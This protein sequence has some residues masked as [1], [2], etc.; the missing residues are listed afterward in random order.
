MSTKEFFSKGWPTRVAFLLGKYLPP[1]GGDSLARLAARLLVSVDSD[2]RAAVFDNQRHVLGAE[3]TPAAVHQSVYTVFRNA[4]RAYYELFH[5]IGRG[6]TRVAEFKPPVRILPETQA[7]LEAALTSGRGLFLLGI[8]M[9]NFDLAGIALCQEIP[10]PVQ[11][12]G[13]ADP[14][15]GFEIF[16]RLRQQAGA[17]ITPISPETLRQ[18]IRRLQEGGVVITGVDRPIGENDTPVTFFGAQAHLPTGYM[19][20]ALRARCLLMT[21]TCFYEEGEYRIVANPP[22]EPVF[23]GDRERDIDINVQ[24]VLQEVEGLIRR[25]PEQWMMF[26]PVWR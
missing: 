14:A 10:V 21:A 3:A 26:V 16:N 11:V 8:H 6:H 15:P 25:H 12:L 2:I 22:W 18:A 20:I 9:S 1:K 24:K 7:L 4:A 17:M 23:T 5:N 19:R 13:L